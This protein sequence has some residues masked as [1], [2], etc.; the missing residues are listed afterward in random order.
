MVMAFALPALTANILS[1][2]TEKLAHVP[3]PHPLETLD[4]EF[5]LSKNRGRDA[6]AF[7][8]V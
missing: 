5:F 6:S 3:S 7:N 4:G 2:L 1:R 8:D